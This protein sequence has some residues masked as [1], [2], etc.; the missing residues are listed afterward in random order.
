MKMRMEILILLGFG[1]LVM[2]CRESLV[3][4]WFLMIYSD[5]YRFLFIMAISTGVGE[6]VYLESGLGLEDVEFYFF[7]SCF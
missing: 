7:G 2:M 4:S 5:C 1:K 3:F 6:G